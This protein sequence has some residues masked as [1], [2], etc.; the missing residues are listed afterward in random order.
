DVEARYTAGVRWTTR[1]GAAP[2]RTVVAD[3]YDTFFNPD[4]AVV[5]SGTTGP[6]RI[7]SFRLS[8]RAGIARL[9]AVRFDVGYR[10]RLDTAV[11][12]VGHKTVTRNGA[13]VEATDVTTPEFTTS[14]LHEIFAGVASSRSLSPRWRLAF[15][16]DAAPTTVGRL[17]V[18][19]PDKYPGQDLVFLAKVLATRGSVTFSRDGD[20]PIHLG[21]DAG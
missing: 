6:A 21:V 8:Q 13:L 1:V 19:L 9:S 5:V 14:Q 15:A 18:Q 12:G 2:P 20:W 11:F 3:D 10:F 4:G 16:G 7:R 17:L